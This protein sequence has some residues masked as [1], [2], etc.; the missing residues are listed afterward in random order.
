MMLPPNL[1]SKLQ[2]KPTKDKFD[3]YRK[4]GLLAAIKIAENSQRTKRE[5]DR[6]ENVIME[7]AVEEWAD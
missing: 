5:I 2:D 7:W 4:T 3:A 1:N 6:R